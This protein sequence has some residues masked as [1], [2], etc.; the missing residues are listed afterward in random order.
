MAARVAAPVDRQY[1][2][3]PA[4]I[5]V[6]TAAARRL[7]FLDVHVKN[8]GEAGLIIRAAARTDRGSLACSD[9]A[10]ARGRTGE[11]W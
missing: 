2:L 9:R 1:A 8:T 7:T 3:G 4:A 5:H 11:G 6:H 10:E